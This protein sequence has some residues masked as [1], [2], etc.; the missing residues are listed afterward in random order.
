MSSRSERPPKIFSSGRY[1][2]MELPCKKKIQ[3]V[4]VLVTG[5]NRG[6]VLTIWGVDQ[7]LQSIAFVQRGPSAMKKGV[8]TYRHN[9]VDGF[10]QNC[11]CKDGHA[12][13]IYTRWYLKERSEGVDFFRLMLFLFLNHRK[14]RWTFI[15]KWTLSFFRY[16]FTILFSDGL[17]KHN[18]RQ[19]VRRG[20]WEE[21]FEEEIAVSEN[22]RA[23]S[24]LVSVCVTTRDFDHHLSL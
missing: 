12:V 14:N 8:K 21:L 18:L 19:T 17:R 1:V 7:A 5:Q 2:H 24:R 23:G 4:F 10:D 16:F 9:Q 3:L 6:K 22:E 13:Q 11:T 20:S 15:G